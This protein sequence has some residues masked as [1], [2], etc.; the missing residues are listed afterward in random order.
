MFDTTDK[1]NDTHKCPMCAEVIP[2]VSTEC[3][4]CGAHFTVTSSGYCETCHEVRE[5][6]GSGR[7]LVCGNPVLDWQFSTTLT[8]PA[9]Q[10]TRPP[11]PESISP[12]EAGATEL[13]I[14]PIKGEGVNLR[15]SAIFIDAII[16]TILCM[17]LLSLILAATRGVQF[18]T[19][20][21]FEAVWSA[22]DEVITLVMLPIVW[23][24]Y[25]FVMEGAFGAT[26]GKYLSR[27]RVIKKDGGQINFGQAAI[28][29]II[30]FLEINPI[31]AIVI[32]L[33]PLKQRIGDL[34]AHTMVVNREKIHKVE[35]NPPAIAFEFHDHHQVAYSQIQSGVIR[36]FGMIRELQ[37]RGAPMP[38][39][40]KKLTLRGQFYR[41]EFNMLCRNIELRYNLRFRK[42]I[43][44]WRL[45][46]VLIFVA[47]MLGALFITLDQFAGKSPS[48]MPLGL[49]TTATPTTQA[50]IQLTA[51]I[52]EDDILEDTATLQPSSTPMPTQTP[53]PLPV[54]VDFDT[55]K[56]YAVGYPVIL[57]GRLTLFSSTTCNDTCGL[58]LENP[59][60]PIQ[61]T[62]IF[63]PVGDG[64][65][66]M[67]P[68]PDSFT[69][70]DIQVRL[71]DGTL[72]VIGYRIRVTG[73]VCE[74]TEGESCISDIS[75][76]ELFQ[77]K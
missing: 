73:H 16:V 46:M 9:P 76:M 32:W 59:D 75:K 63:V 27:L 53:T 37:L 6:D 47:A 10:P 13:V 1:T 2:L 11:Q 20:F 26:V 18:L 28:R 48:Q 35:L 30:G 55:L 67:K 5:A 66:Q 65:N 41:A 70:K 52:E 44:L 49:L 60:N 4:Y 15:S 69:N 43:L 38:G 8:E 50:I 62:T 71:D 23:F 45:L 36:R 39:S 40:P 61:K 58:L 22:V 19:S 3:E 34:I 68:L 42:R 77:V 64:N 14:L 12:G 24:I 7:C 51:T 17:V 72:A 57:V 31:G 56:N 25:F 21:E 54:E 29:A 33:T 74:T